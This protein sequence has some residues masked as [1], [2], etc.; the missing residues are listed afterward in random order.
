MSNVGDDAPAWLKQ[1]IRQ[2]ENSA[3]ATSIASELLAEPASIQEQLD[4]IESEPPT[5]EV[6]D[7]YMPAQAA[8]PTAAIPKTSP[9]EEPATKEEFLDIASEIG[10]LLADKNRQYGDAYARMAHV[11][12]IF[13]PQ[14]VPPEQLLDAVFI[15]RIV[16][17]LMRVASAQGDDI[18]D[19]VKDI[20]GYAILR[21]R[22]MRQ[23]KE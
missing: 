23:D 6:A 22:E 20:A 15:L 21:M 18:E 9:A 3:P 1:Q 12:P 19:P 4:P 2:A 16:D 8:T 11:L 14:G 17:K 5:L 13:Y 7:T 10:N